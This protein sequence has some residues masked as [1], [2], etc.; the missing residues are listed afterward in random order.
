MSDVKINFQFRNSFTNNYICL[1]KSECSS[2]SAPVFS[3]AGVQ[4]EHSRVSPHNSKWNSGKITRAWKETR[5]LAQSFTPAGKNC[6]WFKS[7]S[8]T[9]NK[10]MVKVLVNFRIGSKANS[11]NKSNIRRGTHHTGSSRCYFS[12][13]DYFTGRSGFR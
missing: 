5:I 3:V 13:V 2:N 7:L 4:H 10:S 11:Q 12:R 6:L 8:K 9:T 1:Q